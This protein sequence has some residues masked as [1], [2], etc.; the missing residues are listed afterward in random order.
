V[1]PLTIPGRVL[2]AFSRMRPDPRATVGEKYGARLSLRE[3]ASSS[4]LSDY[5]QVSDANRYLLILQKR[6]HRAVGAYLESRGLS[7]VDFMQQAE[8]VQHFNFYKD[9]NNSVVG[10]R[11]GNVTVNEQPRQATPHAP[12]TSPAI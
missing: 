4:D 10:G 9:V 7:V 2:G 5:M 11:H 12:R 6:V 8:Q 3:I 1:L